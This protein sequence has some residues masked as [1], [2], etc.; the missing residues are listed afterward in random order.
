MFDVKVDFVRDF[1]A[2]GS[3]YGL[4]TEECRECYDD[5]NERSFG[6]KHIWEKECSISCS[7]P[8]KLNDVSRLMP[9]KMHVTRK[10]ALHH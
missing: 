8:I 3:L 6:E 7:H 9:I 10:S 4:S 2:T 1:W 5:K